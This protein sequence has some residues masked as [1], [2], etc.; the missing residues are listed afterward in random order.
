MVNMMMPVTLVL[1]CVKRLPAARWREQALAAEL[2][3]EAEWQTMFD[4][5]STEIDRVEAEV[6]AES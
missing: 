5:I 3:S 4:E 1:N 2:F 6:L